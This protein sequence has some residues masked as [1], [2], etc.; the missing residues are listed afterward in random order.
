MF[1]FLIDWKLLNGLSSFLCFEGVLKHLMLWDLNN[2][3]KKQESL[4][5]DK[6]AELLV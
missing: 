4:N 6:L 2:L 3:S 5:T 1:F